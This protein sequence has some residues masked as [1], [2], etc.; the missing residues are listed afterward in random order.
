MEP[1]FRFWLALT[2]KDLILLLLFA[3]LVR[4]PTAKLV[5]CMLMQKMYYKSSVNGA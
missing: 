5:R 3:K 1:A 4:L 2:D